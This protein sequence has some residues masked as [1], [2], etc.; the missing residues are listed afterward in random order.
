M[1]YFRVPASGKEMLRRYLLAGWKLDRVKGSHHMMKKMETV[2]LFL[3]TAMKIW[4]K[5]LRS[6]F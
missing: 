5:G 2:K 4:T 6:S 1:V 3:F